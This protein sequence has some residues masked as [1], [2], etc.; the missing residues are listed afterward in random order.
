M[1][2]SRRVRPAAPALLAATVAF[3]SLAHAQ[4]APSKAEQALKYRKSLYQVIVWNFAPMRGPLDFPAE[5]A[6]TL[7]LFFPH[8]CSGTRVT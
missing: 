8:N 5:S 1:S 6:G 2:V 3:A 7:P 4:E